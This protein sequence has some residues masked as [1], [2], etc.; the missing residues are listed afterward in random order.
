VLYLRGKLGQFPDTSFIPFVGL[1]GR[2]RE[3]ARGIIK[4]DPPL[5]AGSNALNAFDSA[6]FE[7]AFSLIT[8]TSSS[9]RLA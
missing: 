5:L 1:L 4:A 8:F 2:R 3:Q 7:A 9:P 6:I